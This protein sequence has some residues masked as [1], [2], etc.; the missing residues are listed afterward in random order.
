[1]QF[2]SEQFIAEW[3][4]IKHP[5]CGDVSGLVVAKIDGTPEGKVAISVEFS[6]GVITNAY[7]GSARGRDLELT[8]PYEL[9]TQLFCRQADPAA[10]YMKGRLKMSGDM[11]MWLELLP[12]W[13]ARMN[14]VEQ[15]PLL[16]QTTI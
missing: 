4:A 12:V 2:L 3:A 10:E 16:E 15:S 14:H 8:M 11:S 7:L 9:A 1:M 5:A 13:Q 6:D